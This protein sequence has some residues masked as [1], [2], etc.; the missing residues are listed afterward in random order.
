[1]IMNGA[2][3]QAKDIQGR[4][5]LHLAAAFGE[6]KDVRWLTPSDPILLRRG[7][8]TD[9]GYEALAQCFIEGGAD[10]QAKDNFGQTSLQWA[11]ACGSKRMVQLL[12]DRGA[13]VKAVSMGGKTALDMAMTSGRDVEPK[14]KALHEK[15]PAHRKL[16]LRPVVTH[17][18]IN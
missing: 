13:D 11:A 12:L 18:K 6:N 14:V 16:P 4:T 15:E 2:D 17:S 3:V 7:Q 1:L 9:V 8:G 10:I 5:L